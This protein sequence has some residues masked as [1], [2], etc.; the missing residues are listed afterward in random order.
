MWAA[1]LSSGM[2]DPS[3][4]NRRTHVYSAGRC[5]LGSHS[6]LATVV[7]L[8]GVRYCPGCLMMALWRERLRRWCDWSPLLAATVETSSVSV[9]LLGGVPR[10]R[11]RGSLNL[12]ASLAAR[13]QGRGLACL[14]WPGWIELNGAAWSPTDDLVRGQLDAQDER[15]PV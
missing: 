4:D 11:T 12:R 15:V 1:R 9:S 5:M 8:A 10:C 13:Q 14:T 6:L 7:C 2:A 3:C